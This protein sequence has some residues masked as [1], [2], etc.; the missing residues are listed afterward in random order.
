[1]NE[2]NVIVMN[3]KTLE[4]EDKRMNTKIQSTDEFSFVYIVG[5]AWAASNTSTNRRHLFLSLSWRVN[6]FIV[7]LLKK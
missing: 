7:F 2:E 4:T 6:P 1:M 3:I 5:F